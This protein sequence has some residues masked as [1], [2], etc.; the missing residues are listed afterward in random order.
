MKTQSPTGGLPAQPSAG[1][2]VNPASVTN[3]NAPTGGGLTNVD[4]SK[5][6]AMA[7]NGNMINLTGGSQQQPGAAAA[8]PSTATSSAVPPGTV[9]STGAEAGAPG[10]SNNGGEEKTKRRV[11]APRRKFEWSDETRCVCF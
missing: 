4:N 10:T 2:A 7:T 1:V 3:V 9:P 8:V 11:Y 6:A 5:T